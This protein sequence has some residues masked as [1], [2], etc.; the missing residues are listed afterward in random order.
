MGIP[1]AGQGLTELK[2]EWRC[3]STGLC[4][5]E[6]FQFE[7]RYLKPLPDRFP[8]L[9]LKESRTV[10]RRD[11]TVYF[12]GNYYQVPQLYIDK[13]VLCVHTGDEIRIYYHG[14]EISRFPYL[15]GA[16]GMIRLSEDAIRQTM[17][18]LSDTVRNWALEVAQR[19]VEIYHELL[20]ENAQ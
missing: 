7:K 13:S 10:V 8:H 6:S 17:V 12:D 18:P 15:P 16:K 9:P 14:D 3:G 5:E 1:Q 11:G 19:Q 4:V 2:K 20:K